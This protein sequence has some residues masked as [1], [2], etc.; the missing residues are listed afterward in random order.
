[1]EATSSPSVV[2]SVLSVQIEHIVHLQR[3]AA[4]HVAFVVIETRTRRQLELNSPSG[5]SRRRRVE[6]N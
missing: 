6:F 4:K 3:E 5:R 2:V 1:M